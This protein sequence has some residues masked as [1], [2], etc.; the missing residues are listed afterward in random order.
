MNIIV[1]GAGAIGSLYAA[2]LSARHDVTVVAR[3]AHAD[4]INQFGLRLTGLERATR[5]VVAVT[6]IDSI[7]R[8]TLVLLTTK[9]NDN[10]AAARAIA[11]FVLADTIILCIQNGLGGEEIVKQATVRAPDSGGGGARAYPLVLRGITQFGAIFLEPGVIDYKVAGYTLIERTPAAARAAE[12]GP[13]MS[14]RIAAL[15][16]ACGLDG[17]VSENIKIEVW[18]KLIFNC[19]INPLTSIMGTEVGAIAEARLDPIKRLV[20]DECL[21]VARADGVTLDG[22]TGAF[23][24]TLAAVFGPSRNVASMRQDLLKAKATEIDFMNGAVVTLGRR[25]GIDCPVNAALVA[26]IKAMEAHGRFVVP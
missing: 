13:T 1:Y 25:F 7:P 12:M 4:A 10:R 16:S 9:V 8:D 14:E 22:D 21:T 24:E 17:R 6:A 18:R 23:V 15:F 2:K 5:R 3:A 11:R 19:V 26:I 20:I